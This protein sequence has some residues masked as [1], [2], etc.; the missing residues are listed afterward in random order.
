M[1][2]TVDR[3]VPLLPFTGRRAQVAAAMDGTATQN[4][5][6]A[7]TWG[8]IRTLETSDR[9]RRDG[10]FGGMFHPGRLSYREL[11]PR[12]SLHILIDGSRVSAHVDDFCPVRCQAE[13]A[14]S[15]SAAL[16]LVHNLSGLIGDLGRRLR[17]LRGTQRCN[18]GCEMVWVD[19]DDIEGLATD[20][21]RGVTSD[22]VPRSEE[23]A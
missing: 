5:E 4:R 20:L 16:V 8:L 3:D 14:T 13:G 23:E 6:A 17:G 19:D 15:Y 11:R 1:F 7:M 12:D 9:F 2:G 10:P 22:L 21:Q 18:L